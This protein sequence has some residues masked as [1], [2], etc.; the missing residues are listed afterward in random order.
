VRKENLDRFDDREVVEC[1]LI[2]AYG[3]IMDFVAKH[4]SKG[5][6]IDENTQTVSPRDKH[7]DG[8]S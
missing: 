1:N 5:F 2:K 4:L 3:M 7:P 6:Y 8:I